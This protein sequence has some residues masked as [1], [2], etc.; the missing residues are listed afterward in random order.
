MTRRRA[1]K[2]NLCFSNAFL[3]LG[4]LSVSGASNDKGM[5]FWK[6]GNPEMLHYILV[7]LHNCKS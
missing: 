3:S 1:Q 6:L 5:L 7:K 4:N 2:L